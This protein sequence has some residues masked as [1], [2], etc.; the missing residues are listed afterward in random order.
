MSLTTMD[1]L[2]DLVVPVTSVRGR[3]DTPLANPTAHLHASV[4]SRRY[5]MFVHSLLHSY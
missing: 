3:S 1:R 4:S 2:T 5:S